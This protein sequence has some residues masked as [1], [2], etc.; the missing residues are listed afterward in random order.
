MPYKR[1][2]AIRSNKKDVIYDLMT[3]FGLKYNAIIIPKI[4]AVK[5]NYRCTFLLFG[6]KQQ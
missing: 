1:Q 3:D 2:K 5:S 6:I 4:D